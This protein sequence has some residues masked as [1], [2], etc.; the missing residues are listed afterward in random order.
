MSVVDFPQVGTIGTTLKP[1]RYDIEI[2]QGDTFGFALQFKDSTNA[3]INVTGWSA[4]AQI[5]NSDGT[6][7][8]TAAFTTVIGTTDGKIT[9]KLTDVQSGDLPEGEY[10]YDVQV[11]DS[12]GNKRTYIGGRITVVE[13]ISE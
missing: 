11:T 12:A 5:K 2:Y 9:I 8:P 6:P 4:L 1:K 7:A 3:L 10:K 13:D